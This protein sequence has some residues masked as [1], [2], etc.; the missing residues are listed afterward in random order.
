MTLVSTPPAPFARMRGAWSAA[1]E[2]VPG[3]PRWA[4]IAAL[5]V[6]FTVLPSGLWRIAAFA[7]H[8]PII[9]HGDL[10]P[11]DGRGNLPGWVPMEGYVVVLS[12]ASEALAF[13]AVGLIAGWGERFP[14]WIPGLRGRRVPTLAAV[15][16]AAIGAAILTILWTVSIVGA[17]VFQK[18]I[19][20]RPL[21]DN[22]P[23][24]FHSWEGVLGVV[25]YAPLVAWGPLLAAV[26]VAYYRRRTSPASA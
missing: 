16:P 9:R 17:L 11:G 8:L 5:I 2:P 13:T 6:P 15:V 7:L 20:G 10:G 24:H 14:R 18:T 12:I 25:A 21:A 23:V 22:F 1:H 4:R 26:T 3:V 19:Q